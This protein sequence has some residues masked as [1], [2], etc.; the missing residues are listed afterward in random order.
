MLLTSF[1]VIFLYVSKTE[2]KVLELPTLGNQ[3]IVLGGFYSSIHSEFLPAMTLWSENDVQKHKAVI[4]HPVQ[5]T[6]WTSS[7][8]ITEKMN[9]MGIE[10]GGSLSVDLQTSKV[11][12]AGSFKYL[13]EEKV[14][15]S[16]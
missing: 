12:A 2:T 4:H 8:T 6:E 14:K 15:D 9:M 3:P 13:T 5:R 16:D 10:V 7:Q 11:K 1:I